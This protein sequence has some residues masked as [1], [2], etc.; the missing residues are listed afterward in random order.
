MVVYPH[1]NFKS[2]NFNLVHR[3]IV[4]RNRPEYDNLIHRIRHGERNNYPSIP[5]ERQRM[6]KRYFGDNVNEIFKLIESGRVPD[7]PGLQCI[8]DGM[9]GMR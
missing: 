7:D 9:S 5:L 2:N 6:F 1:N 4:R 8:L 3:E